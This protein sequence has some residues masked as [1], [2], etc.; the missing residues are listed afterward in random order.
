MRADFRSLAPT[1]C[2]RI[3]LLDAPLLAR[4]AG[5]TVLSLAA[6]GLVAAIIP[7][8]IFGRQIPPEPFAIWV[9]VLSAPLMGLLVATYTS[10]VVAAPGATPLR[11][12]DGPPEADASGSALGALAGLGTF[13]AI[14]CPVCNK[15]ALL[16]LG[17]SGALTVFAPLQ[18]VIGA[19]SLAL[20]AM[21]LAWR[22]RL[23]ARG[24]ACTL[25]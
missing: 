24:A 11:M 7:N 14:G 23:R 9:W 16:L 5:W 17:A 19:A 18:P 13:V 20:L 12:V 4:G 3:A 10:P 21:T 2:P 25:R 22:L 15:V 8:P 1:G 6:F